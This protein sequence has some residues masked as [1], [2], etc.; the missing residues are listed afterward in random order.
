MIID[1]FN[2]TQLKWYSSATSTVVLP[3]SQLL[4]TST[5]Y[6]SS[7]VGTCESTRQAIQVTVAATVPAPTATS[8]VACGNSTLND[9]VVTKD[10]S[11][12]LQ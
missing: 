5:Y 7:V 9:L 3:I 11:A 1:G 2:Y 6:V 10:P 8:Q 4:T 12:T